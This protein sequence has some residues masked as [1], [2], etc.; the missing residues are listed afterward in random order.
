MFETVNAKLNELWVVLHQSC[1]SCT[2][3]KYQS[4]TLHQAANELLYQKQNNHNFYKALRSTLLR[5]FGFNI[6]FLGLKLPLI[7]NPLHNRFVCFVRPRT[8]NPFLLDFSHLLSCISKRTANVAKYG[9]QATW[10]MLQVKQSQ[11]N[12]TKSNKVKRR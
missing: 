1:S 11:T 8:Q 9:Q 4:S 3:V 12:Q 10:L 7:A 5:R 2:C 6:W